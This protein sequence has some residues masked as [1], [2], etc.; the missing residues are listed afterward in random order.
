[1]VLPDIVL[2]KDYTQTRRFLL[3]QLTLE[4]IDWWGRAFVSAMIDTVSIVGRKEPASPEHV[5]AV[6]VHDEPALA[7]TIPQADFRANPRHTFNLHM[8]PTRRRVLDQVAN[9]P[10]LGD[11]FEIHEGVHSG[12]M[13]AE[14]FVSQAVD[15]SCRPLL[16]GRDEISPYELRWQGRYIRLAAMPAQ[17]TP[18]HTPTSAGRNGTNAASCWYAAPAISCSPPSMTTAGM[19][20]TISSWCSPPG[21]AR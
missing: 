4:Q 13:R 9:C 10:R 7:H 15:D 19:P 17:R 6:K 5:V 12:N 2:L 1:M 14:L 21:R 18:E 11:Y 3:D 8:T 16:F 20:V